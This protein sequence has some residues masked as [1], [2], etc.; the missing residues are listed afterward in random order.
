MLKHILFCI[1]FLPVV[2]L[3]QMP[4][5]GIC[6]HQGDNENFPN[7]TV[8]AFVSAVKLGA[9]MVEFDI[10]RCKTGELVIF[11][12]RTVDNLT[13]GT[14]RIRDLTFDEVRK[15]KVLKK[16]RPEV[17]PAQIPTF[18][19][20][21]D[22]L[23]RDGVWLNVH[24]S[25]GAALECARILE[26][27]GRLHQ[28][29]LATSLS[30]VP[31]LRQQTPGIRICNMSRTGKWS[32]EWTSEQHRKYAQQTVENKCEFIQLI[33]RCPPEEIKYL[34]D[35]GVKVS[36][37]GCNDP[38]QVKSLLK[39]GVDFI[40]TDRLTTVKAAYDKAKAELEAQQP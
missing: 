16:R 8:P 23:P 24:V 37:M 19:E 6:A 2:L 36:F 31:K 35:N 34:H 21:L 9:A 29:F 30:M 26:K 17:A 28:A 14:G 4:S 40:L 5:G 38:A 11:H 32:E 22:C 13:D 10:Q 27:D 12:D 25:G 20:V 33:K 3:A 18:Q 15:L 39:L 7:N 1:A